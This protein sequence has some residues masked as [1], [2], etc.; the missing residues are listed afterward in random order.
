MSAYLVGY[1]DI[2]VQPPVVVSI[3]IFSESAKTLTITSGVYTFDILCSDH[4]SYYKP[5][6]ECRKDIINHMASKSFQ[7]HCSWVLPLLE[8]D[9]KEDLQEAI[10]A[11]QM[12]EALE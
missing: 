9:L 12:H 5:Y 11:L 8:P 7:T 6:S 2:K 10:Q 4:P 3:G 1:L